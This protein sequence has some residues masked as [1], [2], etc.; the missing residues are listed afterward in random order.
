VDGFE[1][2]RLYVL[3][4]AGGEGADVFA[5]QYVKLADFFNG[6]HGKSFEGNMND[7]LFVLPGH[8]PPAGLGLS[9]RDDGNMFLAGMKKRRLQKFFLQRFTYE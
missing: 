4:E 6:L 8:A 9:G 1:G 2:W 7:P 5:V 3:D